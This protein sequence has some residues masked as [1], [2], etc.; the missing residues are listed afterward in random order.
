MWFTIL[1]AAVALVALGVWAGRSTGPA[2]KEPDLPAL[3]P[4]E[5]TPPASTIPGERAPSTPSRAEKLPVLVGVDVETTSLDPEKGRIL[6]VAA[7]RLTCTVG[8]QLLFQEAGRLVT[9]V[10]PER[11]RVGATRIHGITLADVR[12]APVFSALTG[13]LTELMDEAI[14]VGH[15]IDFD[16]RFLRASFARAGQPFPRIE[17]VYCTLQMARRKLHL[18]DYKLGTCCAALG[19][20]YSPHEAESDAAAGR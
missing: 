11:Q 1:L 6:S 13:K 17:G 2:Q 16:L 4:E 5:R 7:I 12:D 18:N 8:P 19:I 15:N 10:N 9:Y 3:H 14:V 20:A